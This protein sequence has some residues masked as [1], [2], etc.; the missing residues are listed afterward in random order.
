[1]FDKSEY[2]RSEADACI[3]LQGVAPMSKALHNDLHGIANVNTEK[4]KII[5]QLVGLLDIADPLGIWCQGWLKASLVKQGFWVPNPVVYPAKPQPYFEGT[6]CKG[7][8]HLN[9]HCGS[10][11]KCRYHGW[12]R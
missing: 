11:E 4:D 6:I 7:S 12:T 3:K 1:M 9:S 8:I 2:V 5:N 10:C